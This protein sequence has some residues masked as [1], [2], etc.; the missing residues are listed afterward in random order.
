MFNNPVIQKLI[1]E[2]RID[3][4]QQVLRSGE[5]GMQTFDKHMVDLVKSGTV[6]MEEA[7]SVVEDEMSFRR[8]LRGI[9]AGSDRG[10]L[11]S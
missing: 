11:I 10:G 2:N 8:Q 6:K 3:D 4:I 1:V 7:L 9:T 5:G